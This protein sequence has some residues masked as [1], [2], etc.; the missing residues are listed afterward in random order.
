MTISNIY[1]Y[2]I[3]TRTNAC[4]YIYIY[5]IYLCVYLYIH[6]NIFITM[7]L[8]IVNTYLLELSVE[9]SNYHQ[10]AH[11]HQNGSLH[12]LESTQ[13]SWVCIHNAVLFKLFNSGWYYM[14]SIT[15]LI[16]LQVIFHLQTPKDLVVQPLSL[17]LFPWKVGSS[18]T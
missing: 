18:S 12:L 9:F 11:L 17:F 4:R 3:H 8:M 10:I 15:Y 7:M 14:D 6:T 13:I 2:K 5:I 16:Q 1:M